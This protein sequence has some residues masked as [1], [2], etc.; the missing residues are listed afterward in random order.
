[1]IPKPKYKEEK[2]LKKKIEKKC[3]QLWFKLVLQKYGSKCENC[4]ETKNIQAHHF[5]PKRNY[6]ILKFVVE[7]GVP[8][9]KSC[10]FKHHHL[11]IPTIHQAIVLGRGKHWY[12][13]L[14]TKAK[15]LCPSFKTLAYYQLTLR[16]LKRK[17][18]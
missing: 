14:L 4:G 6:A 11:N 1:M 7:N 12:Q 3:E 17:L 9:C 15:E 18:K 2:R 10:H 8:T 5:F 16:Q 13:K